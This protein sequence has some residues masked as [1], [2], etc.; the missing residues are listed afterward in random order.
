MPD[1]LDIIM[2]KYQLDSRE[3]ARCLIREMKDHQMRKG[4]TGDDG[5]KRKGASPRRGKI[6]DQDG[7][8]LPKQERTV[9]TGGFQ[10]PEPTPTR[11]DDPFDPISLSM[12]S[13]SKPKSTQN[14]TIHRLSRKDRAKVQERSRSTKKKNSGNNP[15]SARQA[16][17][18]EGTMSA[19][20]HEFLVKNDWDTKTS[21]SQIHESQQLSHLKRNVIAAHVHMVK[22]RYHGRS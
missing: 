6:L 16:A 15:R 13:R 7:N 5:R 18:R 19:V 2:E 8:L 22:K 20:I 1:F 17:P 11:P 14:S 3:E 9:T 10:A 12:R 21:I 4:V